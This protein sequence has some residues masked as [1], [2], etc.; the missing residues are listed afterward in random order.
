MNL[1][2]NL[3]GT[4]S[5]PGLGIEAKNEAKAKEREASANCQIVTLSHC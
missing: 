1:V 2:M 4:R 3:Y 5:H